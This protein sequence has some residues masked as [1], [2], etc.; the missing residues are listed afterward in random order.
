MYCRKGALTPIP[1][2]SILIL[3]SSGVSR[4]MVPAVVLVLDYSLAHFGRGYLAQGPS[5]TPIP[6]ALIV[7]KKEQPVLLDRAAHS[8]AEHVHQKGRASNASLVVEK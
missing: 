3:R 7:Q 2:G 6:A 8:R 5:T 4:A 1:A